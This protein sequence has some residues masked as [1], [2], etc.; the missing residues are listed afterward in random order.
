[1]QFPFKLSINKEFDAVGFG[2]NAVDY[3]IVVPEYPNFN[4]KT[5]LIHYQ[6]LGGGEIASTMAGLKRLGRKTAYV[7]RFGTDAA[8][9]FGLKTLQDEGVNT[10]FA[11]QI[12]G[13]ITQVGFIIIDEKNGERTVI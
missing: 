9:D 7:G 10:I 5:E 12:E 6:Q 2:T 3:L 1:M 11:E 13:A 8:G 4:S